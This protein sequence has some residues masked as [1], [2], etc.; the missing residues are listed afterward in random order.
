ML[1]KE[2]PPAPAL[3]PI[4]RELEK[5]A[6]VPE[7]K[8]RKGPIAASAAVVAILV[9]A[10]AVL[11][12]QVANRSVIE[13]VVDVDGSFQVA[14]DARLARLAPAGDNDGSFQRAEERRMSR[15]AP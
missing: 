11:I 13:A 6:V 8:R 2:A 4:Y 9:A 5:Q 1:Q 15:L 3:D 14:E 7:K 10:L 12:I